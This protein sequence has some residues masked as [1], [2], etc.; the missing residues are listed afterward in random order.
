M[1]L[2]DTPGLP[3]IGEA[4]K[5]NLGNSFARACNNSV[6]NADLV[7][8]VHDVSNS[9]T[10]NVLHP[11]V[12]ETLITHKTVPSIL[13]MNKI[14]MVKSKRILLDLVKILTENTLICNERRYLPWKG[15][16]KEFI[17]DMQRPV[18]YKN[19][20][21][22]GWPYFSEVFMVSALCNDGIRRVAVSL[23][24][25]FLHNCGTKIKY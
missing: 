8:V 19:K 17:A 25:F 4:K 6:Q 14:D 21:P 9:Y 12:L 2:F 20:K 13:V 3:T 22:A 18:K 7:A 5:Y 10:R 11:V 1:I 23:L 15:R 24:F 16:E